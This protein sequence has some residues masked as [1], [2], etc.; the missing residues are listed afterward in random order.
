MSVE[1]PATL[2][3]FARQATV[4]ADVTAENRHA[5]SADGKREERLAHG[6]V[7]RI[8]EAVFDHLPEIGHEVELKAGMC[9]GQHDRI[10]G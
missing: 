7:Y 8:A 9:A 4:A 2:G 10:D 6:G 3:R 5:R 1:R